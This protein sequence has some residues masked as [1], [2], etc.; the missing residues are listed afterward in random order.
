MTGMN[1]RYRKLAPAAFAFS[2]W[3]APSLPSSASQMPQAAPPRPELGGGSKAAT[4]AVVSGATAPAVGYIVEPLAPPTTSITLYNVNSEETATF[5]IPDDG[6]ADPAT[7]KALKHFLRCRRTLREKAIAP[8]T[9]ALLVEV[10]KHWPGRT[11][12]II[13][14]FRAP[15]YGAPHSKHFAGHAIDLRVEGVK[16]ATLRDF[17]WRNNHEVGVGHYTGENFVHM[18]YRPGETDMAWSSRRE[19]ATL[20]YKPGWATRARRGLAPWGRIASRF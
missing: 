15:P 19:G 18:D 8:G 13:S 12:D 2:L 14:G 11:I 1:H 17:V 9:L 6:R 5:Q 10:A 3:F 20:N 4:I 7:A 16:T